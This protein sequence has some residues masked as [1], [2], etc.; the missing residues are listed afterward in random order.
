LR[1]VYVNHRFNG[2]AASL[3]NR[4]VF[5]PRRDAPYLSDLPVR[6]RRTGDCNGRW[7][8]IWCRLDEEEE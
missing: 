5:R 1:I 7:I 2:Y 4:A 3:E 8:G 6:R